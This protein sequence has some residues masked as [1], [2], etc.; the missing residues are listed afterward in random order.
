[1]DFGPILESFLNDF[2]SFF[3]TFRASI[4]D[5]FL[6][7]FQSDFQLIFGTLDLQKP[8]YFLGRNEI[9]TKSPFQKMSKNHVFLDGFWS[10]CW[11]IVHEFSCFFGIYFCIDFWMD[12]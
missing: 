11:L 3:I 1:M 9:F 8:R 5:D 7:D 2:S 10:R 6:M 12:F 4:L